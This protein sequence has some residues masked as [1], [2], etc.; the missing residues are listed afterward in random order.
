MVGDPNQM[1][2]GFN[3]SSTSYLCERFVE[4]FRPQQF[5]LKKNYRC[6]KAVIQAANKLKMNSQNEHEAALP[7]RFTIEPCENEFVEAA[8]VVSQIKNILSLQTTDEIEGE[9]NLNKMVVIA[10]NRFVFSALQKKLN[11]E[12]ILYTM[13][14]G[15]RLA[16][17]GSLFGKV[18]DFG[19]RLRLNPKDW[20]DGKKLCA[21]LGIKTPS[22]WG[23]GSVLGKLAK[24]ISCSK[25]IFFE[26]PELLLAI[27]TMDVDQPNIPKFFKT[28]NEKLTSFA[29]HDID[30]TDKLELER[31]IDELNEFKRCWTRFKE[32]GLGDS[33][34]AFRNAMALG[35]LSEDVGRDGL[36][37]STVHTMKG[38][39]KDIVF[40]I[41]MCEG[42]FPDYR[43]KRPVDIN[44]ERNNAFVAVTRAKRWLYMSYPKSRTMPWGDNKNQDQSRFLTEIQ[45]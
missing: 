37:L 2:Y 11:E 8:W 20:I 34:L 40:I 44:E 33:L 38:L 31:S 24:S 29:Q 19:V 14:K 18:L 13:K 9:I 17:P 28:F 43:A 10:R 7:G 3:G 4:D 30:D 12:N 22:E 16:E 45:A 41:G 35:Q 26:L 27:Q 6:S 23:D 25:I 21:A 32:K 36:V 42:V 15:E 1:I 39:E 5:E